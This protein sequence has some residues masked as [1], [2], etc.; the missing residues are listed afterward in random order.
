MSY[1]IKSAKVKDSLLVYGGFEMN[2]WVDTNKINE[3]WGSQ[4]FGYPI[5]LSD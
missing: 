4:S 3:K 2:S 1:K 5:F